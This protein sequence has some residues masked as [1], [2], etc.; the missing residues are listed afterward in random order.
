MQHEL[1]LILPVLLSLNET[2]HCNPI[3]YVDPETK[4]QRSQ[5]TCPDRAA[6]NCLKR[7]LR[8]GPTTEPGL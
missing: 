1:L 5:V 4:A 7:H 2:D 6:G 3:T 8:P